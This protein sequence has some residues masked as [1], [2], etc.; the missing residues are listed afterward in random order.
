[1]LLVAA[2]LG[3]ILVGTL[4]LRNLPSLENIELAAAVLVL[5]GVLY[6]IFRWARPSHA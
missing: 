5:L 6:L 4:N 1:M 2:V 3:A